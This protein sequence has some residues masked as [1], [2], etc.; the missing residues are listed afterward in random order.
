MMDL[1]LLSLIG[2]APQAGGGA[3]PA[4]DISD[5]D[6]G[7][8][9]QD[10]PDLFAALAGGEGD[11]GQSGPGGNPPGNPSGRQASPAIGASLVLPPRDDARL[12]LVAE[13]ARLIGDTGGQSGLA[14]QAAADT[15]SEPIGP[16]LSFA[17]DLERKLEVLAPE[18]VAEIRA[19]LAP[20]LAAQADGSRPLPD[21]LKALIAPAA[22]AGEPLQANLPAKDVPIPPKPGSAAPALSV[23]ASA[24]PIG[25]GPPE[26]PVA[27][28]LSAKDAAVSPPKKDPAPIIGL[29]RPQQ[30]AAA[31]GA[32]LTGASDPATGPE[33]LPASGY[34][35]V[36]DHRARGLPTPTAQAAPEGVVSK[37]MP[38][39]PP[40]LAD[41]KPVRANASALAADRPVV[42]ASTSPFAQMPREPTAGP[43]KGPD[44]GSDLPPLG[45]LPAPKPATAA[46]QLAAKP[47][48][49]EVSAGTIVQPSR[50]GVE[51]VATAQSII[52]QPRPG[53]TGKADPGDPKLTS[54][55]GPHRAQPVSGH[56][57]AAPI[58]PLA[59]QAPAAP[60][61]T[62]P[63]PAAKAI[64]G[65]APDPL[66]ESLASSPRRS[67]QGGQSVFALPVAASPV[68]A[69]SAP[70]H[71]AET[72]RALAPQI[73][74]AIGA[75]QVPGRIEVQLDPP[76][77]GKIEIALDVADQ[78]LRATLLTERHPTGE[79]LRRHADLLLQQL[80]DAGFADVDL[81]FAGRGRDGSGS[82]VPHGHAA[83]ASHAE[84]PP[85]GPGAHAPAYETD[86]L[87]IRL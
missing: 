17:T 23:P 61:E 51:I 32:G 84:P 12:Q 20:I 37:P 39:A 41:D 74:M 79:L 46:P 53:L 38:Q 25:S 27:P 50:P 35:A 67:D 55:P 81:R 80:Q 42:A 78:G 69:Q 11:A 19:A 15:G 14:L 10:F 70:A 59:E 18:R 7:G 54:K 26:K 43:I 9:S 57:L 63:P 86:G 48:V 34:G 40:Q 77:L 21:A 16:L 36:A 65:P 13:L 72:V 64:V 1:S 56:P 85:G 2:R 29:S 71:A 44:L 58:A 33:R 87:D 75:A 52:A 28:T 73:T 62:V 24:V 66:G 5:A 76:E 3:E 82:S 49:A 8:S 30:A 45:N 31:V 47:T 22:P 68:T 4:T 60:L 83:T 6:G